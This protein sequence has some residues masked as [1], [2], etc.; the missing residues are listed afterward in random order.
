MGRDIRILAKRG[1]SAALGKA[2]NDFTISP[3]QEEI[4]V[5][6]D[7]NDAIE[8]TQSSPAGVESYKEVLPLISVEIE[9]LNQRS[10]TE[11]F[12]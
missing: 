5:A 7:Q 4:V 1:N 3:R 2:E 12:V 6:Y 9:F 10:S 11:S 8:Y